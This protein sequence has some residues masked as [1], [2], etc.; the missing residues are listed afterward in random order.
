[1][2]TASLSSLSVSGQR[3]VKY[4][5]ATVT[6]ARVTLD[7]P[8][9]RTAGSLLSSA[10]PTLMTLGKTHFGRIASSPILTLSGA[11]HSAGA[12]VFLALNALLITGAAVLC[13]SG[14]GLVAG[15]AIVILAVA[16][17]LALLSIAVYAAIE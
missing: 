7:S 17:V 14:Y 9:L 4:C 13:I 6:R 8:S 5:R 16:P 15:L 12:L 3:L 2:S 10:L 11:R 1:M